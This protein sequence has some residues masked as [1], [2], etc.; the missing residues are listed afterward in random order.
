MRVMHFRN[1]HRSWVIRQSAL[2]IF[3]LALRQWAGPKIV[4]AL[5]PFPL[6]FVIPAQAGIQFGSFEVAHLPTSQ[7]ET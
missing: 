2:L 5:W 4:S 7:P 6:G 3:R 1:T